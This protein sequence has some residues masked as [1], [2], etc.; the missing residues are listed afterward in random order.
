MSFFPGKLNEKILIF[1]NTKNFSQIPS[2]PKNHNHF[3][4][5]LLVNKKI[6]FESNLLARSIASEFETKLKKSENK[7]NSQNSYSMYDCVIF[8]RVCCLAT[9]CA[10]FL[11]TV[12]HKTSCVTF[13]SV[14]HFPSFLFFFVED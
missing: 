14:V 8:F 5:T 11:F 9:L 3:Q 1:L 6:I 12:S 2:S 10:T 7:L 13:F 4:F